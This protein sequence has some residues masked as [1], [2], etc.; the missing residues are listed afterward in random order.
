MVNS[1]Q[2]LIISQFLFH[3]QL[4]IINDSQVQSLSSY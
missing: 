4:E 1:Q 3:I 2:I